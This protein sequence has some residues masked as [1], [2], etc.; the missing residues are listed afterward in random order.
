MEVTPNSELKQ[1]KHIDN[2]YIQH[3]H[4]IMFYAIYNI[5]TYF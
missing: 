2:V 4:N 3:I 5:L 1:K